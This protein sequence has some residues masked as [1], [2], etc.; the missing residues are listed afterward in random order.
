MLIRA[1]GIDLYY[2]KA[3]VGPPLLLLHGNGED[4]TIFSTITKKLRNHFTVY[5]IDSRNHGASQKTDDFNYEIMAE[6]IISFIQELH[7][8]KVDILG[9]SDGA[10]VALL[11]AMK[12]KDLINK[13]LLLG[14]NL[15]PGDFIT[16]CLD[17]TKHM[18]E[19]TQ[20]P[21]YYMMLTQPQIELE[22]LKTVNVPVLLVAGEHDIFKPETFVNISRALPNA[23]LMIMKNHDHES[24][25]SNS[26]LLFDDVIRFLGK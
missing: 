21:L 26:D 16:E 25:I 5:A 24:Y 20:D 10:I 4:H 17:Y 23:E 2:E 6:D 11:A 3:G 15:K 13:L 7:L 9:F 12:H 18:Y 19:N 8:K 1:N 14:L 22:S